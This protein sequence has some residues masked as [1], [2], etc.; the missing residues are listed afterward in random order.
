[1]KNKFDYQLLD[2]NS[3]NN[4]LIFIY[5]IFNKIIKILELF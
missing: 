3:F 2:A 4:F 1:M 5:C